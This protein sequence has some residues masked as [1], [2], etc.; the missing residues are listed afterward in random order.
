MS[1]YTKIKIVLTV[2]LSMIV[3]LFTYNYLKN[4]KDNTTIV[5]AKEDIGPHTIIKPDMI[6]E[7]EISKK[8]KELFEK[9]SITTK[10]ELENA[11]SK[12]EISKGKAIVKSDDVI[13]GTKEE[14]INKKAM[15]ENGDVNNA[16]FIEDNKRITAIT[17]DVDGSVG[18]KLNTGDFVDVIFTHT[19]NE[20][21][22]FSTTLMQHIEIYDV[23][24]N[25]GSSEEGENISLIVTPEQSVDITYAKRNGK[26]DLVLNSSKGDSGSENTTTISK[27]LHENNLNYS[28]TSKSNAT[29][30]DIQQADIDESN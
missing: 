28:D 21:N 13:A 17:L 30:K 9:D 23:Q 11:I 6:E 25:I 5:I 10:D 22:S 4:L 27:I 19:G 29:D 3:S 15:L 26:L 18:N 14:L 7:V 20:D 24:S 8:D 2:I 16:Y 12:V 1:F